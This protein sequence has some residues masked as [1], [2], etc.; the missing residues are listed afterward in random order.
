MAPIQQD[1]EQFELD[2]VPE[3]CVVFNEI[4]PNEDII[5]ANSKSSTH[6][7]PTPPLD[8]SPVRTTPP[9]NE[10]AELGKEENKKLL[11]KHVRYTKNRHGRASGPCLEVLTN[12]DKEKWRSQATLATTLGTTVNGKEVFLQCYGTF[13]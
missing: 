13:L 10:E 9:L 8:E 1:G 3:E 11:N 6:P 12:P 4:Q 5:I 7:L 2:V